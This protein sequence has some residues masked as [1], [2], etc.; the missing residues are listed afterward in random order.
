VTANVFAGSMKFRCAGVAAQANA[1]LEN[2]RRGSRKSSARAPR[3]GTNA[4]LEAAS[5][6]EE[7]PGAAIA[8]VF[9]TPQQERVDAAGESE[10]TRNRVNTR[11]NIRFDRPRD[12]SKEMSCNRVFLIVR[13]ATASR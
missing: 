1:V 10:A 8:G 13:S 2:E 3:R 6:V 5:R 9:A 11:A 7:V 4:V 12:S